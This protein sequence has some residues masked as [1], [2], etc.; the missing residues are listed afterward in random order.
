MSR[1]WSDC[2]PV[3][4]EDSGKKDWLEVYL[5]FD[6]YLEPSKLTMK[7]VFDNLRMYPIL[8]VM[9]VAG[10]ALGEST[11][12][13]AVFP[14]YAVSSF[15]ALLSLGVLFQTSGMLVAIVMAWFTAR[16]PAA[17]KDRT[18]AFNVLM[19]LFFVVLLAGF[20]VAASYLFALV[21]STATVR[22]RP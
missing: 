10:R 14:F 1:N 9:L 7:V 21:D 2:G 6:T 3:E 20:Y 22:G 11:S 16:L 15:V 12:S 5:D 13:L 4:R 18:R 17:H 8:V 19:A